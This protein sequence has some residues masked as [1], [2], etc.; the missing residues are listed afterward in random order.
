VWGQ[1]VDGGTN[2][3]GRKKKSRITAGRYHAKGESEPAKKQTP[4]K[5]GLPLGKNPHLMY[6]L[7][8]EQFFTS[9][10]QGLPAPMCSRGGKETL[11]PAS[12]RLF[13]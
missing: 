13:H 12:E 1:E 3:E 10:G 2:V 6:F 7:V 9:E 5:T 11:K 8:T 4:E